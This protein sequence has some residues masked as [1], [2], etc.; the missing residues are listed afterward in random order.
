MEQKIESGARFGSDMQLRVMKV[1]DVA[2]VSERSRFMAGPRSGL[3]LC[4]LTRRHPLTSGDLTLGTYVVVF[5]FGPTNGGRSVVSSADRLQEGND[6]M[7]WLP[8]HKV[9]L[10]GAEGCAG[11]LEMF[12]TLDAL[13]PPHSL[14]VVSKFYI[15]APRPPRECDL[16]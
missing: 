4:R 5:S 9:E 3:A 14:L 2:K 7:V 16:T 15:A 11:L 13:T 8:W 6:V 12:R 1:L 10:V